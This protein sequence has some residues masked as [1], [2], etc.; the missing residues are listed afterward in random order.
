M[1][2]P[3]TVEANS[4][5]TSSTSTSDDSEAP[6]TQEI[7]VESKLKELFIEEIVAAFRS[8]S[9]SLFSVY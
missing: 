2:N 9:L 7:S 6:K 5:A 8:K 4:A 1:D 3:A